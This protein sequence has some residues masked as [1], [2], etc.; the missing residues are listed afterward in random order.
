MAKWLSVVLAGLLIGGM[1]LMAGESSRA[2]WD[3]LAGKLADVGALVLAGGP[4]M[5]GEERA[6]QLASIRQFTGDVLAGKMADQYQPGVER[7]AALKL[8]AA[9]ALI[10]PVGEL[11]PKQAIRD[12]LKSSD[13]LMAGAKNP[14]DLAVAKTAAAF[15]A[16]YFIELDA[17]L[18]RLSEQGVR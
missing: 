4:G 3:E 10:E 11:T 18:A 13:A 9:S 16:V 14:D 5:L 6:V 2:E 7:K 8:E 15:V 1:P 17:T 12:V